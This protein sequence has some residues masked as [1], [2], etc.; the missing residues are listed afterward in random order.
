MAHNSKLQ[1]G[2]LCL[3]LVGAS[4]CAPLGTH[5]DIHATQVMESAL[6]TVTALAA[7]P[8]QSQTPQPATEHPG[9]TTR[10][11]QPS[12]PPPIG[13][14]ILAETTALST[15]T[16]ASLPEATPTSPSEA[17]PVYQ[18]A[19][20]FD[21][22]HHRMTV[23]ERVSFTN[24]TGETLKELAL[25]VEA[26]RR[27]GVFSLGQVIQSG[28]RVAGVA[29]DGA[30]LTIPL[31]NALAVGEKADLSLSYELAIPAIPPPSDDYAPVHFGY[32][33]RQTNLVD[34][35]PYIPAYH[36]GK[37]WV[38]H[39]AGWFGEH[40]VYSS[41]DV[42]V[43]IELVNPPDGLTLAA[44]ALP[45]PTETG[46]HYR[47]DGCRNF[48]I[49]ASTSYIVETITAGEVTLMGYSFPWDGQT[50]KAALAN[51][52][53][54]VSVYSR[55]YGP[56][57]YKSLSVVEAD[58]LDGMEYDGLF[59][60]GS[61]FYNLYDGTPQ[62]YLIAISAHETAHQWWYGLVG[63]DQATEPWLDEGLATY[64]EKLFYDTVYPAAVDWWLQ[65]RI[66]YYQPTGKINHSIYD[67]P[68]YG[69]YRNA[70]YFRGALFMIDLAARVGNQDFFAFLR[71]YTARS[72][73]KIASQ[74]DFFDT[75]ATHS[76]AD[77]S[78]LLADYFDPLP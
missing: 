67:Y 70:V 45:E 29:L 20:S 76:K 74:K 1:R 11:P 54:A 30:L 46:Y 39:E 68:G 75:L 42:T 32:S 38:V 52:A 47:L 26:N 6:Q 28:E 50:G 63:N 41:A 7:L 17:R 18:L 60:L 51:A 53:Q 22:N 56:Y 69:Y 35:Y 21:Y 34:W 27:E 55:F 49:S 12:N 19:A 37:G 65:I 15:S 72:S 33:D 40:Q 71:D 59:F 58:F 73:Y 14:A 25:D 78:D 57:P 24:N 48:A 16:P 10:A 31:R 44:S 66:G 8:S 2:I 61:A 77:L 9:A 36:S 23:E 5:P 43:D 64:S 13:T 3:W 62:S 4:A